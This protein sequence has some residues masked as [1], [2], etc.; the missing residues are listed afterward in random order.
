MIGY[1]IES[2]LRPFDNEDR[3]WVLRFRLWKSDWF[4]YRTAEYLGYDKDT[5]EMHLG[6]WE[7]NR[8]RRLRRS[9]R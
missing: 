3:E 1:T 6:P 4:P 7:W 8:P 2:L 9:S 5:L